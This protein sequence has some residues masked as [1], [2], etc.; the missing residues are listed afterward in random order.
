MQTKSEFGKISMQIWNL[1]II[2]HLQS[3]SLRPVNNSIRNKS[4]NLKTNFV[5]RQLRVQIGIRV[6]STSKPLK[7][8][9]WLTLWKLLEMK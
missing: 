3:Y 6:L 5:G 1:N 9:K 8:E 2:H 7:K 4:L